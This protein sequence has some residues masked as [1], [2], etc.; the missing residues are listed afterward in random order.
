MQLMVKESLGERGKLFSTRPTTMIIWNHITRRNILPAKINQNFW[1]RLWVVG[2]PAAINVLIQRMGNAMGVLIVAGAGLLALAQATLQQRVNAQAALV[3]PQAAKLPPRVIGTATNHSAS[4]EGSP[5]LTNTAP[6][7]CPM[8]EFSHTPPPLMWFFK[9]TLLAK[10]AISC[11]IMASPLSWKLTTGVHVMR[12][13][14]AVASLILI[15]QS[16]E[17]TTQQQAHLMFVNRKTQAFATIK[18]DKLVLT[19]LGRIV[20]IVA[21]LYPR[22]SNWTKV[23]DYL[24]ASVG[25]TLELHMLKCLVLTNFSSC[26]GY[27]LFGNVFSL[28][29]RLQGLIRLCFGGLIYCG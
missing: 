10:N 2:L 4:P 19:G 15:L 20:Q 22:T 17:Q 6:L 13:H 29:W 14:L 26:Y 21:T 28:K 24:L 11:S 18:G 23:V 12:I 16:Q 5:T 3:P 7:K 25:I 8:A 9:V 1:T 27:N